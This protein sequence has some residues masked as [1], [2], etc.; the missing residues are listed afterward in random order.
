MGRSWQ[1]EVDYGMHVCADSF[2]PSQKNLADLCRTDIS[3]QKEA[4]EHLKLRAT[5]EDT[6]NEQTQKATLH[7][8]NF[9]QMAELAPCGECNLALK[10]SFQLTSERYVYF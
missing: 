2:P 9:K 10:W 1:L 3:D 4:Q 8:K 7:E 5:L 6:V